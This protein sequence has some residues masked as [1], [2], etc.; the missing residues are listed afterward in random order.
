[1]TSSTAIFT[2]ETVAFMRALAANNKRDWF[3]EN[4][5]TYERDYKEPA[6]FFGAVMA[7]QLETLT[8]H[9]YR[10]KVF[11]IYRDVRFAKDKTPYNTH[12]H[13]SFMPE[14][15]G[16]SPAWYFGLDTKKLTLGVGSFDLSKERLER[17]RQRILANEGEKFEAMLKAL[18]AQGLRIGDPALK[19]VPRGYDA[20][21]PRAQLL[22]HKSLTVW[23]DFNDTSAATTAST[24]NDCMDTFKTMMPLFNWLMAL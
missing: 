19:R 11:R 6:D 3:K 7:E 23:H 2:D 4:K 8:G 21:H 20:E 17:V 24:V 22:R 18:E 12:L 13:I 9:T 1:M 10:A 5:S 15:V 14:G 16:A